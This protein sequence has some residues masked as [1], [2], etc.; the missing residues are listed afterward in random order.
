M[1][2]SKRK[3]NSVHLRLDNEQM[4]WIK[5]YADIL[6]LGITDTIRVLLNSVMIASKKAEKQLGDLAKNADIKNN[7][8]HFVQHD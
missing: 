5:K 4:E 3:Q 6:G 2:P 8:E 7:I 1:E